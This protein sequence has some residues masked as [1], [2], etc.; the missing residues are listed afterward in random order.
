MDIG[1]R[2]GVSVYGVVAITLA[3]WLV[4][5]G[6]GRKGEG[7]GRGGVRRLNT[8]SLSHSLALSISPIL[9]S[10]LGQIRLANYQTWWREAQGMQWLPW[11]LQ[12]PERFPLHLCIHCDLPP[13]P[14]EDISP[15]LAFF[16]WAFLS[17]TLDC[18]Y[19]SLWRSL[20]SVFSAHCINHRMWITR[21]A[22][23]SWLQSRGIQICSTDQGTIQN[24][25]V[26]T[27]Q[28]VI[29]LYL[30]NLHYPSWI[31]PA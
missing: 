25:Q 3:L 19:K 5:A 13:S 22:D 31:N 11:I 10:L 7:R 4:H 6:G 2:S 21:H 18:C 14:D 20:S 28:S 26:E 12:L 30:R 29:W 16:L 1:S 8:F 15:T 17:V 24:W 27:G 9:P 23:F